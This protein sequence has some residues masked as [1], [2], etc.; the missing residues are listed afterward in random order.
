MITYPVAD[1]RPSSV[2]IKTPGAKKKYITTPYGKAED[3]PLLAI[4]V[5]Q[6]SML[7]LIKENS[8]NGP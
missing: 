8:R 7:K 6:G 5:V 2:A 3:A 1:D 4:Q